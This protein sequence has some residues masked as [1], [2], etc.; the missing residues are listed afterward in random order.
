MTTVRTLRMLLS[1]ALLFAVCI[2][3]FSAQ[4]ADV[5]DSEIT[6]AVGVST[7]VFVPDQSTVVQTGGI[8]GVHWTYSVEGQFQLSVD[9]NAGIASFVHVDANATD[10]S[11]YRRTLDPNEVF[12]MTELVGTVIGDTIIVFTGKADDNSD[13]LIIA[14]LN[15]DLVYLVGQTFP[16]AGSADFFIFNMDAVAQRKYGGGN[17]TPDDPYQIATAED[18]ILM[19]ES[20]EDYDKHF[21]LTTDIDLDPN[22]PGGQVFT[23]AVIAPRVKEVPYPDVCAFSGSFNGN[24]C[25]I[26]HLTIRG[27]TRDLLGLFGKTGQEARILNLGLENVSIKSDGSG[28][29]GALSGLNHGYITHCYSNGNISSINRSGALGGLVGDNDGG[30]ITHCYSDCDVSGEQS[31]SIKSEHLGG[32]VGTNWF[33]GNISNCYASGAVTGDFM[34]GGLVGA[35]LQADISNCYATGSVSG[36]L[37]VGGLAGGNRRHSTINN[38][39]AIG[40]ISAG[41]ESDGVGGFVGSN[42][43]E[44]IIAIAGC[45]WD[46]ETS[47]MHISDGGTG[48][49]TTEMQMADTFLE[50]GWDFVDETENGTDDIWWIDEGKDYPRLCWELITNNHRHP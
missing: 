27:G 40:R 21:I 14:F 6:A 8:A 43:E 25:R 30:S 5:N 49:T 29:L 16:P 22:L 48:K 42:E 32:L 18:L 28:C 4:A 31:D 46:V 24:G 37:C 39:F 23:R 45:F 9:P 41:E 13:I 2:V 12:N 26:K 11:P 47:G 34:V 33:S 44:A 38:C 10:D 19:G 3:S 35:N 7:Y 15:D 50:A 17:G 1:I 20:P 36:S